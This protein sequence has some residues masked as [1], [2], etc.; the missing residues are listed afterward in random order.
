MPGIKR[1]LDIS[2]DQRR[3]RSISEIESMKR[4]LS[5]CTCYAHGKDELL[6]LGAL[7]ALSWVIDEEDNM[8]LIERLEKVGKE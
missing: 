7:I 5:D 3:G 2:L 4:M 8:T 6:I 1:V